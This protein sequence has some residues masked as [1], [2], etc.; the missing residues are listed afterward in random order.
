MKKIFLLCIIVF[1][2]FSTG[3]TSYFSNIAAAPHNL[4]LNEYAI[5][6]KEG[7]RFSTR[8]LRIEGKSSSSRVTEVIVT[9]QVKNTGNKAV[10]LMAYP[11]VSDTIGNQYAGTSIF[12]GMVNPGGEFI[13]KSTIFIP[14]D[15]AY[16]A[17]EKN[18]ELS[19]RFQDTKLIPYE[20]RWDIDM[21]TL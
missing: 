21:T 17:L 12:V 19:V 14:S 20:A 6:E 9:I 5:F 11:R 8:I 10:S 4:Q 1:L 3:C 2:T 18:A 16:A 13:G 7:N 15:E